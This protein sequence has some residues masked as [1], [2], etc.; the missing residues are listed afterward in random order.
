VS[1]SAGS[2]A[3]ILTV[4]RPEPGAA[5]RLAA[6]LRPEAAREV[7]RSSATLERK[8]PLT[9]ALRLSA[10]DTGALRAALNAYLGW[11]QLAL[12]AEAVARGRARA[13]GP[14]S[15]AA[16]AGEALITAAPPRD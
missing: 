9:L 12:G 4:R 6:V 11:I 2:W 3:G 15:P 14:A 8:D 16:L 13:G 1:G 10:E 7:P 5:Q